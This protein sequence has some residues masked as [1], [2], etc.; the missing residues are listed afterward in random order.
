MWLILYFMLRMGLPD[1]SQED[2][3]RDYA[4]LV[5]AVAGFLLAAGGQLAMVL[6]LPPYLSR[7]PWQQWGSG[8]PFLLAMT[9][10]PALVGS[11]LLYASWR[12]MRGG[13]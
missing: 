13:E 8:L 1:Y 11:I 9:G 5:G 7:T 2:G 10:S 6:V 3:T 12:K 4:G